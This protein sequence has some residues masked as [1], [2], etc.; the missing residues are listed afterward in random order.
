M[1]EKFRVLHLRASPFVGGPERQI[2]R[3]ASFKFHA[4]LEQIIGSFVDALE[5]KDFLETAKLQGLRTIA[6]SPRSGRAFRELRAFIRKE[7][8]SLICTHGY[9]ADV[10][11]I[12][13]GRLQ[14]IPV[15]SFLR[16]WTAQ[17]W[18]VR[19]YESL[20][21]LMLP[22]ANA[23]VALSRSQQEKLTVSSG[24][25]HLVTNVIE[26]PEITPEK[27]AD[28]KKRLRERFHLPADCRIVASAGRLSPEKGTVYFIMAAKALAER[29]PDVRFI[30]FGDGAERQKLTDLQ[31]GTNIIFAGHTI[32]FKELLPGIDLLVNP[33]LMEEMPNVVLE[34]MSSGVP[35]VA[36]NVGGVPDIAGPEPTISLV[37]PADS[38]SIVNTVSKLLESPA[39]A[40][41]LASL[42]KTRIAAEYSPELQRQELEKLYRKLIPGFDRADSQQSVKAI[43]A[44]GLPFITIAMPVRNEERYI[45]GVLETLLAQ[46]YPKD[47]YEIIVAD[48]ESTDRTR[49]IVSEVAAK[50]PVPIKLINNPKR[51]SSAGRNIGITNGRGDVVA[52]V[53]G[54][55]KIE[56]DQWLR[57]IAE[58]METTGAM[59]LCRPQPLDDPSNTEFQD[60]IAACRGSAL[61]HGLDSSIFDLN[62]E[63][64]INPTS[65]G[66]IYKREVF[67]RLGL[68]DES[69][70]ACEDVELNHRV[71]KAGLPAYISP[72]VTVR[73][74]PRENL[75]GLFKQMSRYGQGRFH[76]ISKHPDAISIGQLIPPGFVAALILAL[77]LTPFFPVARYT[78]VTMVIF[79]MAA[80]LASSLIL[81]IRHGAQFLWGG[82]AIYP[83]IHFGLGTGFWKGFLRGNRRG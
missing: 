8:I 38:A 60:M 73:Y 28:A 43:S 72:K 51:L 23:V 1:N 9:K 11:A 33:S 48:G 70:D 76:F 34:A 79:Y 80:V 26:I 41:K 39:D 78:L 61:G 13:A 37:P 50:V 46:D 14:G 12:L 45:Q 22:F 19:Q 6:F 82:P 52:F 31:Q 59:C 67:D 42:A 69:F 32:D 54:H 25:R 21:R 4:D 68:Y 83:T 81:A 65:S 58:L 44:I 71:W 15:A 36:T 40:Y 55:C 5:G 24:K 7:K 57:N 27:V 16:G 10:L 77:V 62:N 49:A 47:K 63:K 74:A 3:C 75:R 17:D 56:T 29:F 66:A 2:L 30:I 18:K 35:I 53:D 20:D 64:F